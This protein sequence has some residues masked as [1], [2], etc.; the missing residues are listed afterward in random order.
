MISSGMRL[1]AWNDLQYK[2]IQPIRHEGKEEGQVVAAKI[3][4][5]CFVA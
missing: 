4:Y 5:M 1:G 2:H 3:Q